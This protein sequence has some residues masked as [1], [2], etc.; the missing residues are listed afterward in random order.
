MICN[1]PIHRSFEATDTSER[2]R[3][4]VLLNFYGSALQNTRGAHPLS[5]GTDQKEADLAQE[6]RELSLRHGMCEGFLIHLSR[7]PGSEELPSADEVK[8]WG[9]NVVFFFRT[10]D[11]YNVYR[12]Q[13]GGLPVEEFVEKRVGQVLNLMRA[14]PQGSV[15]WLFGGEQW[16]GRH[17]AML[18]EEYE[19]HTKK[20]AYQWYRKWVTTNLHQI[21]WRKSKFE[22]NWDPGIPCVFE[23]LKQEGVGHEGLSLGG[24]GA[25]PMDAH[26]QHEFG[27]KMTFV[28]VFSS[29]PNTQIAVAFCRGAARQYDAFWTLYHPPHMHP[30]PEYNANSLAA[31]GRSPMGGTLVYSRDIKPMAGPTDSMLLRSWIVSHFSGTRFNFMD[32]APYVNWAGTEENGLVPTP[33]G[34]NAKRFADFVLRL[35]LKRGTTYVPM[36]LMMEFCHGWSPGRTSG[37][38][39]GGDVTWYKIPF[40][41]A[42]YMVENFFEA[43]F[44]EHSLYRQARPWKTPEEYA[45]M[46][47]EGFDFRPYEFKNLTSSLWG[48]SFDVLLDNAPFEVIRQYPIVLLLGDVQLDSL[49]LKRLSRYVKKGGILVANIQQIVDV[50]AAKP[51]FGVRYGNLQRHATRSCCRRCRQ[52]FQE[53]HYTYRLLE[54]DGASPWAETPNGDPLATVNEVGEGKAVLTTPHYLQAFDAAH[55]REVPLNRMPRF[56]GPA[57]DPAIDA[58]LPLNRA[59]DA[60]LVP[61]T[62]MLHIAKDLVTHLIDEVALITVMGAHPIEYLLN[63]ADEGIIAVLVN[64]EQSPWSGQIVVDEPTDGAFQVQELWD[65]AQVNSR[66]QE[67]KLILNAS[68]PGFGIRI[69]GIGDF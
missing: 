36:A 24:G 5:V 52:T 34:R 10:N 9:G 62:K 8:R 48:D 21:H 65:G 2:S 60:L 32:G 1:R 58:D 56:Y 49:L 13:E 41:P 67:G 69:Y 7:Y 12:A 16:N 54:L 29:C 45:Q 55:Q 31:A 30:K 47:L 39:Y 68:V 42:D 15:W 22:E 3:D 57:G 59:K 38:R 53:P 64:N 51:L 19:F 23:Y 35:G 4:F 37:M 26:Y 46:L 27:L 63:T 44:P 20:Q 14:L 33:A 66:R 18:P 50:E 43:A 61:S 28:E 6:E 40:T 11:P 25:T 17:A